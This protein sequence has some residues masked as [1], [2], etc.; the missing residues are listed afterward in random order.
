[1]SP[2][3]LFPPIH[4]AIDLTSEPPKCKAC[5]NPLPEGLLGCPECLAKVEVPE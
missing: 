4:D 3:I 2:L 1:M 5:G